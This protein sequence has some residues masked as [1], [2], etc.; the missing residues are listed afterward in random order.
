VFLV[1]L[2]LALHSAPALPAGVPAG[3]LARNGAASSVPCFQG[4]E[5]GTPSMFPA[6]QAPLG[7]FNFP[8][9]N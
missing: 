7:D 6:A 8:F 1:L 4:L 9:Q 5:G 3:T 2:I